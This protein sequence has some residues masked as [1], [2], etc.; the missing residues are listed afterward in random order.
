MYIK[1][2]PILVFAITFSSLAMAGISSNIPYVM[3]NQHSDDDQSQYRNQGQCMKEQREDGV[4]KETYKQTCKAIDFNDEEGCVDTDDRICD[5]GSGG[6]S[7]CVDTE[8][9]ICDGGASGGASGGGD[10]D[11]DIGSN[12]DLHGCPNNPDGICH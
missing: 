9:E 7:E 3:A 2:V 1:I 11:S 6:D 5:G 10:D 8:S 4:G 12:L